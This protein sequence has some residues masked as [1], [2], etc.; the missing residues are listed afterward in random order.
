MKEEKDL[1][2]GQCMGGK[3]DRRRIRMC[4]YEIPSL[5][6][7]GNPSSVDNQSCLSFNL[8]VYEFSPKAHCIEA[9]LYLL[10]YTKY[11]THRGN[12]T[13]ISAVDWKKV[14]LM[15]KVISIRAV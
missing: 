6:H 7:V 2:E 10:M 13:A 11:V 12:F 15:L 5:L 3:C 1:I 8:R 14:L 4:C 9:K